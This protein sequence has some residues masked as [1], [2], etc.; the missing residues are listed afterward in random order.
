MM[1]DK[2]ILGLVSVA[3]AA[4]GYTSYAVTVL[5]GRTR[6]H[7]LSWWIWSLVMAVAAAVQITNGAG[8]GAWVTAFSAAACLAIALL[9]LRH[10]DRNIA[11]TDWAALATALMII[12]VWAATSDPLLAVVMAS[13]IEWLGYYPTMRKSWLRPHEET[14]ITYGLDLAKWMMSLGALTTW[15]VVTLTY[16]LALLA[17]NA[18]L[19]TILL[20]RRAR[21]S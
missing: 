5:R 21:L 14:T 8:A 3:L 6:P 12:P 18:L 4:I 9:S 20:G 1:T 13:A 7:I 16:P 11:A 15:S 17:A 19:V 2:A 10:G